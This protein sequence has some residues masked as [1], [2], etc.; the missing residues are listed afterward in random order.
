[1]NIVT[2][3]RTGSQYMKSKQ[4]MENSHSFSDGKLLQ[5]MT[6]SLFIILLVFFI[7]L[8]SIA[9][10]NEKKVVAAIGSLLGSFGQKTGGYS[11][12]D[13][14]GEKNLI[15]SIN[16]Y[17]G[18]IDFSDILVNDPM[19]SQQIKILSAPGGSLVR[20]S[21]DT[22]FTNFETTINP[23]GYRFLDRIIRAIQNNNYPV[24]ISSHTDN[25]PI[26]RNEEKS[27]QEVSA[28]RALHIFQ[29]VT[30]TKNISI[31]RITAFGWGEYQPAYS[32]R[33]LETRKLNNRIDILFVHKPKKQKPK[34]GFIFK[35]F[36]FRSFE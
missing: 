3:S 9:V 10:R 23:S 18:G 7:L 32:N 19:L 5:L 2:L 17:T 15:L 6:I 27:N 28:M 8:N 31:D 33:T 24:E 1:M 26:I 12:I 11:D 22:L 14:T 13:G 29:Y 34:S 25:I 16:T 20:I 21:A 4:K 36:F 30:E 35:D